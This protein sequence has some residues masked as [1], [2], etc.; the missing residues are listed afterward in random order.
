MSSTSPEA[1]KKHVK[2]YLRVFAALAVL[3]VVTVAVSYLH[4]PVLVA[5]AL[6]LAIAILKGSLVAAYFMH[7]TNEKK[8]IWAILLLTAFFFIFLLLYPA[9]HHV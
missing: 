7:L 5:V 6:A 4:L 8:I 1:V 3:T 2:V 9:G